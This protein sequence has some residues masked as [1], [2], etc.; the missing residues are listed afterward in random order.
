NWP[1]VWISRFGSV[2]SDRVHRGPSVVLWIGPPM[3]LEMGP[4]SG[5]R[6]RREVGRR[7]PDRFERRTWKGRSYGSG[8][9]PPLLS[10]LVQW[11]WMNAVSLGRSETTPGM[12]IPTS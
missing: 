12:G 1:L 5:G 10:I 3:R 9:E 4:G 8:V 6:R 2:L 7:F 11:C